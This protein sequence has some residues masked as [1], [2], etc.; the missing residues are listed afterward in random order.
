MDPPAIRV[1]GLTKY[2]GPVIG[3]EDLSFEVER[4]EIYGFLGANGAGKTTTIRLLL[5]L[6][7]PSRGRVVPAGVSATC[8]AFCLSI[9]TS[10]RRDSSTSWLDSTDVPSR[11]PVSRRCCGAS[12]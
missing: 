7:R 8:P 1:E 9:P 4:G 3:V 6:L 10:R 2:Y 5:D 11:A 12:T